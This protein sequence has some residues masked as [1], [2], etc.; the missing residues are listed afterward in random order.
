LKHIKTFICLA[1][2]LCKVQQ[3]GNDARD[4][5]QKQLVATTPHVTKKHP[6]KGC[7]AEKSVMHKMLPMS[8]KPL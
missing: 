5:F 6:Q 2:S 3:D 7:V 4:T 8:G 1:L